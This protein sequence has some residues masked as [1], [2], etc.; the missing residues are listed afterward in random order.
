[1]H[2]RRTYYG[3]NFDEMRQRRAGRTQILKRTW[4][5]ERRRIWEIWGTLARVDPLGI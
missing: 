2:T 5:E 3:G 1:M 4:K